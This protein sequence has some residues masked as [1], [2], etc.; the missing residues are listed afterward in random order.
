MA[1]FSPYL[2]YL[3][4]S[5]VLTLLLGFSSVGASKKTALQNQ[6]A[7]KAEA[8]EAWEDG[9]IDYAAELATKLIEYKN[10]ASAGWHLLFLKAFIT[11]DYEEALGL[12]KKIDPEYSRLDELNKTVVHAFL[13]LGRYA[14]AEEFARSRD[15]EKHL[16]DRLK[17]FKERPLKVTLDR[18]TVIPFAEGPL[19]EYFPDFEVELEGQKV[20][21]HVDTGGTFLH[22]A[23]AR[24]EKFGIE[25]IAGGEAYHGSRRVKIY[26]GIAR[27]FRIGEALFENVP[28]GALA[29]LVGQENFIIFGTNILQKFLSTLDY[30]NK[31]LI[32]SPRN[33]PQLRKNHLAMLPADRVKIPFFMGADHYMFTRGAVGENR[34]LNF[35]I[36][37]GLVSLHPDGRGGIRQAAFTAPASSFIKWGFK[38]EEVEQGVFESH[39]PL[40]FGPLEQEGHLVLAGKAKKESYSSFEGVRIDGLLSHAFLKRYTWTLDFSKRKYIFSSQRQD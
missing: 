17:S 37:S 12:Y 29:S 11:G 14:K 4:I 10:E 9:E 26:H 19:S 13:H 8:W 39:L 2:R 31:R 3:P 40:S 21:A 28:V 27:S 25:L 38:P 35:F 23:P 5:V 34:G 33:N 30:P 15:M 16:C 1:R 24:A 32:L 36:D 22:M 7:L 6:A 18:L 20:I